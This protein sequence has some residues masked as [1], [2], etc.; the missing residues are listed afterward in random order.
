MITFTCHIHSS[1]ERQVKSWK[2][3]LCN[4]IN[5]SSMSWDWPSFTSTIARTTVEDAYAYTEHHRSLLGKIDLVAKDCTGVSQCILMWAVKLIVVCFGFMGQR[6][7]QY[8]MDFTH[9]WWISTIYS[10]AWLTPIYCLVIKT[11]LI[12]TAKCPIFHPK[13]TPHHSCFHLGKLKHKP[14]FCMLLQLHRLCR[15]WK[16][17]SWLAIHSNRRTLIMVRDLYMYM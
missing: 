4:I 17:T 16:M 15:E 7:N 11:H 14:E 9:T 2:P 8:E 13:H 6:V 1:P 3:T 5:H 10:T 12:L